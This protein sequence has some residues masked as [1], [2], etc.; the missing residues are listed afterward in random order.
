MEKSQYDMRKSASK[1]DGK[2]ESPLE[3]G[4]N[5]LRRLGKNDVRL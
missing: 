3:G 1:A 4:N 5:R 2:E